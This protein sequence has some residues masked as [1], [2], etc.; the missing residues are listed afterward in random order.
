MMNIRRLALIG[1][2]SV[3]LPALSLS[4]KLPTANAGVYGQY[5]NIKLPFAIG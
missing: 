1:V 2:F 3:M 5:K 4:V